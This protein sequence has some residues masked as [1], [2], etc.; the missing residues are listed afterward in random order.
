MRFLLL[1]AL[2]LLIAVA[3]A[4]LSTDILYW[5]IGSTQPSILAHLS[6]DPISMKSDIISYHPPKVDQS[7]SLVRLGLY[8]SATNQKQWVGSLVSLS[9]LAS[10]P[11]FRLHLGPAN[12]VYSVSLSASSITQH[13]TSGPQVNLI[14]NE[15]GTSPH[16][17]RPVVV[18]PDGQNSDQ[19]EEKSLLQK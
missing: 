11:T 13:P 16:L 3:N 17:N 10:E 15:S 7:D 19:P 1:S 9:S 5:P 8:T 2:A 6:Y 18:R 12:E 4:S 14:P